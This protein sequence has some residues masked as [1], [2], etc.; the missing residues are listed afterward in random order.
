MLSTLSL[1][2]R[3]RRSTGSI[4]REVRGRPETIDCYGPRLLC[5]ADQLHFAWQVQHLDHLSF[6]LRGRC[7]TGSERRRRLITM[8]PVCFC[9][10]GAAL[11]APHLHFAWQVQHRQHLQRGPGKARRPLI[12]LDA[13]CFCVACAPLPAH[14]LHFAWQAQNFEHSCCILRGR[15]STWSTSVCFGLAGVAQG[16]RGPGNASD[17]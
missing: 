7:S 3:G 13:L 15:R 4:S 6:I 9:V 2:L 11:A 10:A 5:V 14:L 1:I 17:D 16:A 12:T 8:D